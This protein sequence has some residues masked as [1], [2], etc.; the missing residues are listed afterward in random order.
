MPDDW[1][2]DTLFSD[3]SSKPYNPD[4]ANAFFRSGYVEAWGQGIAKIFR[5]CEVA[6][7]PKPIIEYRG[8][9]YR[10]E[11]RKD[12]YNEEYLQSVGI[13]ERQIK[14]LMYTKENGEIT[15]SEY[16]EICSISKPTAS[17]DI[18]SLV[19]KGLLIS[20]GIRGAG[21]QYKL[22]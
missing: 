14:A 12:I 21:A 8:G 17:R 11:F 18:K 5:E 4:I 22:K 9:D 2:I 1:T 20:N 3:H 7:I 6:G 15:N 13:S 10:V 19:D 16:Q